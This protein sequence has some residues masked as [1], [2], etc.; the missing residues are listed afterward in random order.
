MERRDLKPAEIRQIAGR[1]GRYGMYDKGYVGATPEP[2]AVIRAGLEAVVPPLEYAVVGFSDLVLQVDF[3]LSGGPDPVEQDA[4][5]GAVPESWTSPGISPSSPRCGRWALSSPAIRNCERPTFPL[6]RRRTPCGSC[7]SSF[8]TA[9]SG[10]SPSS[11]RPCRR[12][13]H[14]AGAGAVLPEAG[15]LLL[16]CQGLRLPCGRG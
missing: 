2:G 4:H 1:A 10:G 7:S 9:G 5:G 11:S 8:C 12:R 13:S 14:A 16:L 3:D 6:T 15:P